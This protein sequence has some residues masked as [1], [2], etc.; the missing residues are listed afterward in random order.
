MHTLFYL[1]ALSATASA[2]LRNDVQM[3]EYLAPRHDIYYTFT[4]LHSFL[5]VLH[6]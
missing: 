5:P 6:C 1:N 3:E 4:L 2:L